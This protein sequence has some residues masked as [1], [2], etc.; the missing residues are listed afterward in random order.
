MENNEMEESEFGEL[1]D[2]IKQYEDA[3]QAKQS[4]FFE[5][6]SFEQI[7]QFYLDSREFNKA[8][9]V[10][11]SA[12]EQYPFSANFFIKKG[13]VLANQK[14]FKEALEVLG[15]AERLDPNNIGLFL[16]RADVYLWDGAYILA[17]EEV[18]RGL[19]AAIEN[20]D[21]SEL[22]LEMADIW[23][24]QEKYWEVMD[25][26]KL[27]LKYDPENE[28]ALNRLWFCTELTEKF[29]DSI[30][31]HL[32]L[33]DERPYSYLAWFNL[34]HAYAGLKMYDKSIEAFSY[35][36]A[37]D[38][39]FEP[40]YTCS[41]D[42]RYIEEDYNAALVFYLDAIKLIKPNK[43]L[44]L[45]AAECFEKMGDM[46]KARGY[47]RKA[48]AVDP[49]FDEAFYRIGETY[50]S[51]EKF[52]KAISSFER[53]VKLNKENIDY[54]ASLAEAYISIEEGEKALLLFE[55]IF[56]IDPQNKQNWINL[57]TAYFNVENY[58]KAFQVLVEAEQKYEG[59]ADIYYIKSVFYFEVGNRHE[60][61]INLERGLLLNF[62]EHVVIFEMEDSLLK[63][64]VVLQVIEQ[65]R[66]LN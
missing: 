38:D 29:E 57:A 52:G 24:D 27:A 17:K 51:V 49:Y 14:Y 31:F 41:G 46:G 4:V 28:E 23:E 61:L 50:L 7:I 60:A 11:D 6:D 5:E 55:R 62:E 43:D 3:V 64:S 32:A 58:R 54:L 63:D 53:A 59:S 22:Y 21:F 42:I 15:E 56:Q 34:G 65:Y 47:L 26:L 19:A 37:I 25:N 35:V 20:E 1:I 10:I 48:I 44:Y 40:A 36:I 45:K 12:L 16:I 30:K 2:L 33:I 66:P 9:K 8:M 39:T 18:E 13:E